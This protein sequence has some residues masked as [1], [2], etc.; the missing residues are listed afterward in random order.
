MVYYRKLFDWNAIM[1]YRSGYVGEY[2]AK[3]ELENIYGKD[4]VLKIAIAQIGADFMIIKN[5][6]LILLVEVKETIKKKYYPSKKEKSQ[7]ERIK[8]FAMTNKTRAELWIYYRKGTGSPSQKEIK[9]IYS[10]PNSLG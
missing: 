6:R 1:T 8:Q 9:C 5:G 10:L 3:K 2:K 7:F 4:S